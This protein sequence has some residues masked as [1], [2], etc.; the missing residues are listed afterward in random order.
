MCVTGVLSYPKLAQRIPPITC[1]PNPYVV[2]AE[3]Y[4][5]PWHAKVACVQKY[6]FVLFFPSN[7]NMGG[8]HKSYGRGDKKIILHPI[9]KE[10]R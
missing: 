6:V 5:K 3:F 1:L 9:G 2:I 8:P 10:E 4:I 7:F